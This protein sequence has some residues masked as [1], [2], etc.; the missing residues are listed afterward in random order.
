VLAG[1][2]AAVLAA[3]TA[4]LI[5]LIDPSLAMPGALFVPGVA[6]LAGGVLLIRAGIRG[7]GKARFRWLIGATMLAGAIAQIVDAVVALDGTL[8]FPGPGDVVE[9]AGPPLLLAAVLAVPLRSLMPHASVRLALDSCLLAVALALPLWH[10]GFSRAPG[11]GYGPVSGT[12]VLTVVTVVAEATVVC[13]GLLAYLRDGDRHLLMAWF[14]ASCYVLADVI[15]FSARAQGH[16]GSEVWLTSV[17]WSVAW[18]L[19]AASMF[20]Y[21]PAAVGAEHDPGPLSLDG[22]GVM[23]ATTSSIAMLVVTVAAMIAKPS[24][25][26]IALG[27]VILAVLMFWV[28]ELLNSRLRTQ[29]LHDLH[30]EATAD[31]LTGLA[32]RRV[33]A[34]RMAALSQG[35]S[36]CLLTVDLDGFKDVN[37]L[38]GHGTGDRLLAAV[39]NR[40]REASPPDALVSRIG[41]DEFAILLPGDIEV[42]ARV[43][44][45]IVTAVRQSAAGIEGVARVEV[46][47]SV[48]VAAVHGDGARSEVITLPPSPP[49]AAGAPYAPVPDQIVEAA[50]VPAGPGVLGVLGVPLDTPEVVDPLSAL[51]ASS[52]ALR[53][54]KAGGRNRVEIY[55][56]G[57]AQIR[58]RRLRV[59]ERLR[60]AVVTGAI[61]VLY[62]PIVD[63]RRG[64]L[65]GCEALARWTD[66]ELGRVDPGEFITVAEQTGQ[67]VEIGERVLQ[68]AL[69]NAVAAGLFDRGLRVSCNVSPVQLRVPGFH[70]VVQEAIAA[71]GAPRELV[72]IEVTEQVLVEEGQAAQTLN[73][74]AGLG[75]TIA[76]DDFGTG[77]SALGYLQRLPADILKIDRSLT[78]SLIAE[79]RSRAITRAVVD[80]GRTV[81]LSVVVE[82]VESGQ[83]EDLVRKMGVGFGQGLYYGSPMT[84]PELAQLA[85]RLSAR[86]GSTG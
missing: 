10:F 15:T 40:L 77:Y 27:L 59:E 28:R 84:A 19:I 41:G 67:V 33:L 60:S 29:L 13:V 34:G 42:G 68:E 70:R 74:L 38:L 52:A 49:L 16:A 5:R 8:D 46:S 80:L 73:R 83:V 72:V 69:G 56:A 51:S 85:D 62:Q 47:A 9:L 22:R 81:G 7:P 2:A 57:V 53:V 39:A 64:V 36:W 4:T 76:I 26:R 78:S 31:P 65:A 63:L 61:T 3:G 37:D 50:R 43:G 18:P 14:G 66:S 75:L 23:V 25:D 24:D 86:A 11:Y 79:P 55:D 17:L 35:D 58:R 48:G 71:H 1:L 6:G 20:R 21:R 54:A 44:A 12:A 32:N 82:G 45:A 30:A